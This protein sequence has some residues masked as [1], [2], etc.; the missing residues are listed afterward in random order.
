VQL[1]S[2]MALAVLIEL[3]AISCFLPGKIWG[4]TVGAWLLRTYLALV[5]IYPIPELLP[6]GWYRASESLWKLRS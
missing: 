3:L 6:I 2:S 4:M 5:L 1:R